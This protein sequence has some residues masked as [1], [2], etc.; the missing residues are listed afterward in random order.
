M[1]SNGCG[2]G[3]SST[4][5]AWMKEQGLV[6]PERLQQKS[7][8][9][10]METTDEADGNYSDNDD[11]LLTHEKQP[12]Q[13][14]SQVKSKSYNN[15]SST[16]THMTE[17]KKTRTKYEIDPEEPTSK[18]QRHEINQTEKN[19]SMSKYQNPNSNEFMYSKSDSGKEVFK[20]VKHRTPLLQKS[21]AVVLASLQGAQVVIELK[22]D[23]EITGTIEETDS[24][25]NLT[26]NQVKQVSIFTNMIKR[27]LINPSI[28]SN[29]N[30]N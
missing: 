24:N 3:I 1:E 11:S 9:Y 30:L 22:N 16:N 20:R 21:L 7:S 14:N 10:L 2:R 17:E 23:V 28:A 25:M 18:K 12:L 13:S 27:E 29:N 6:L 15:V 8:T 5:P 26:L 4:T 19:Q